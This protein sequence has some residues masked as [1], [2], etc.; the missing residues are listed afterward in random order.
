DAPRAAPALEGSAREHRGRS[1]AVPR[2]RGWALALPLGDGDGR[3]GLT[4]PA[5][6][7]DTDRA[8]RL[9]RLYPV[10]IVPIWTTSKSCPVTRWI[11]ESSSSLQRGS[12]A[13]LTYQ[14]LPLSAT[15]IP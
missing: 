14:S 15:N 5:G 4:S 12:G 9:A 11:V 6:H 8:W 1:G 2:A 10:T 13:P 3:A 7:L